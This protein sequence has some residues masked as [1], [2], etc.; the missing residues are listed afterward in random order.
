MKSYLNQIPRII[1]WFFLILILYNLCNLILSF[2]TPILLDSDSNDLYCNIK[3]TNVIEENTTRDNNFNTKSWLY[4]RMF[5]KNSDNYVS[6]DQFKGQ[7]I[8]N[9]FSFK[10]AF[11]KEVFEFK[12]HPFRYI[13]NH[14]NNK[15]LRIKIQ[16][17][18]VEIYHNGNYVK[19]VG[20]CTNAELNA[21]YSKGFTVKINK[22]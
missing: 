17:R 16:S 22:N 15:R 7:W 11:N 2:S 8:N 5:V 13:E 3:N 18:P 4:W 14:M 20:M 19:N 6:Y 21:L 1:K 12:N 10:K 9:N